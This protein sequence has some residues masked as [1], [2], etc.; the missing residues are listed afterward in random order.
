MSMPVHELFVP[1]GNM[2]QPLQRPSVVLQTG[3]GDDPVTATPAP[4]QSESFVHVTSAQ[5]ESNAHASWQATVVE[6]NDVVVAVPM[7]A[8]EHDVELHTP[9]LSLAFPVKPLGGLPAGSC[10]KPVY[11]VELPVV[12][13]A[14]K[15]ASGTSLK[16]LQYGSHGL[17]V[18]PLDVPEIDCVRDPLWNFAVNGPGSRTERIVDVSV[19]HGP[20]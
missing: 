8:F 9:P 3:D 5:R 1:D 6:P 18:Q 17:F 7:F 13:S 12:E 14:T 19:T 16:V 10:P 11:W 15:A 2:M 4:M 20:Q